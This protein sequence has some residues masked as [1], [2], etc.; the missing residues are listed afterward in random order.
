MNDINANIE[1]LYIPDRLIA[2]LKNIP[3]NLTIKNPKSSDI[4][5]KNSIIYMDEQPNKGHATLP[6]RILSRRLE[7]MEK[8]MTTNVK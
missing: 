6:L 8:N 5:F 7:Y 3:G 4:V 1:E 2:D